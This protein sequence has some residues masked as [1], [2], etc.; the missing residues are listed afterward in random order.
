MIKSLIVPESWWQKNVP[1]IDELWYD[2]P[3]LS[4]DHMHATRA[5][6]ARVSDCNELQH[7]AVT[8]DMPAEKLREVHRLRE[9]AC[10]YSLAPPPFC[11]RSSSEEV[12]ATA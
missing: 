12:G 8:Y 5:V 4:D 6:H 10:M 3:I 7:G 9:E 1:A 11:R 2:A